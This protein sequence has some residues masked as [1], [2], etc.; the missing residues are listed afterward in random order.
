M[1][2]QHR[3]GVISAT[4]A[5]ALRIGSGQV[6]LSKALSAAIREHPGQKQVSLARHD[7][8]NAPPFLYAVKDA[9]QPYAIRT[10]PRTAR[11]GQPSTHSASVCSKIELDLACMHAY[12]TLEDDRYKRIHFQGDL[13][14]SPPEIEA[15]ENQ[16]V[17]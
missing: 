7:L 10:L 2:M 11:G 16:P 14:S 17:H 9:I 13:A 3:G 4:L 6:D 1:Y 5:A 15:D 8:L 12:G